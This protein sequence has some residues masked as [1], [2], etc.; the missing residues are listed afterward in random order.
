MP[1]GRTPLTRDD[2]LTRA[3]P[4]TRRNRG[5]AVSVRPGVGR[6]PSFL[7]AEGV[8][9]WKRIV[10][11]LERAGL[12]TRIDRAALTVYCAAWSTFVTA[13]KRVET[14]GAVVTNPSGR[15]AVNPWLAILDAA[16]TRLIRAA[17][18]FGATPTSRCRA[19]VTPYAP[20][21]EREPEPDARDFAA[22]K[23]RLKLS[24]GA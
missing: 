5:V 8:A 7:D 1:K 21:D 11:E 19:Y 20:H 3:T 14:E 12:L 22:T 23:P 16:A 24:E 17:V 9:E 15:K 6:C 13:S 18:Q 2:T 4:R 10:P